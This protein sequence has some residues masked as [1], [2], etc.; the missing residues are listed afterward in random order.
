[1]LY[2]FSTSSV[3]LFKGADQTTIVTTINRNINRAKTF[4]NKICLFLENIQMR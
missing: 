4:S 1:M 3:G 2:Y